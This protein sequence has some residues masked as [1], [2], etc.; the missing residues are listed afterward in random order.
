[1]VLSTLGAGAT[2]AQSLAAVAERDKARRARANE[3]GTKP[4]S[5]SDDDLKNRGGAGGNG[6]FSV[7]S[8]TTPTER[9]S[10]PGAS[11]AKAGTS[12]RDEP[13]PSDPKHKEIVWR[14]RYLAAQKRVAELQQ[15]VATQEKY[16]SYQ[17]Q[18]L[19]IQPDFKDRMARLTA[20]R[21]ELARAKQEVTEIK[22]AAWLD[23][24]SL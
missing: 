4:K 8:G 14:A 3:S 12:W 18:R 15:D 5:L 23:G 7:A 10:S 6:T 2:L 22:G 17:V 1:M 19:Q 20:T 21:T 16:V 24:V 13:V 11:N 9:P